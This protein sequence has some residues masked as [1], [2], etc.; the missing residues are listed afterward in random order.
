MPGLLEVLGLTKRPRDPQET[1]L[2]MTD[3]GAQRATIERARKS[4]AYALKNE[5]DEAAR[6]LT[7]LMA[8]L[9]SLA[10]AGLGV[11]EEA[12]AVIAQANDAIT[13][14]QAQV[15]KAVSN[16]CIAWVDAW[17][18][19]KQPLPQGDDALARERA[20]EL[21]HHV[22]SV[23]QGVGRDRALLARLQ[24]VAPDPDLDSLLPVLA[25]CEQQ[26]AAARTAWQQLLPKRS[27]DKP[28]AKAPKITR[29]EPKGVKDPVAWAKACDA[30]DLAAAQ[31]KPP[32]HEDLELMNEGAKAALKAEGQ[33]DWGA[34]L[35][36]KFGCSWDQVKAHYKKLKKD[37]DPGAQAFMSGYWWFRKTTVDAEMKKLAT[38]FGFEWESVGSTNPESDYDISVRTHGKREDRTVWDYEIVEMFNKAVSARFNGV[39]PGTLFDTN[40][41]ASAQPAEPESGAQKNATQKDMEAM[42][43]AG[44]D[45]G[46][47]MKM[48]RYMDWDDYVDYQDSALAEIRKTAAAE[49]NPE[50]RKLIEGRLQAAQRQFE[51]AD[52]L[53]FGKV[54]QTLAKAGIAVDPSTA[55]SPAGQ[56]VLIEQ[57]EALEKNP[58]KLMAANNAAYVEAMKG[59]R[60][61]E[62]ALQK[63]DA[64]LKALEG[65]DDP[66]AA[67]KRQQAG[68]RRAATM[69]KLETLQADSVFF[70]A[71]AYHSKGPFEHI[72]QAGQKSAQAVK[73]DPSIAEADQGKAIAKKV[74]QALDKLPL[75]AFMQSFNEQLGDLL[76]DLK[77]YE[78]ASP[79][80]GLGL[81]RSSKYLE[82]LCDAVDWIGKKLAADKT[83]A[84]AAKEFAAIKLFGKPAAQVKAELAGL[85][86]LRGG[87]IEFPEAADPQR[88]MEAWA[89]EEAQRV[90]GSG[91]KTLG[92]L[93]TAVKAV[94]K[95]VNIV[96]RKADVAS[97]AMASSE[98]AYFEGA[99]S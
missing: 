89:M 77:H 33:P 80:P 82:R 69:A 78:H 90:F 39:Q 76:K 5:P 37:K 57:L 65:Q 36:G 85:V 54:V 94:G 84:V 64:E 31:G 61:I 98:G 67:H 29:P 43:E 14:Q 86:D 11:G 56:K 4:L 50:R 13:E 66:A 73:A 92:D 38:A 91:V 18:H 74:A 12:S 44:Q 93:G 25:E 21:L 42:A 62:L 51:T 15:R 87:K 96:L 9:E 30:V 70:A 40:L 16:R 52:A 1:E 83:A 41:Y 2:E 53:Y 72:V 6:L 49:K 97:K 47:L 79:Y 24:R 19:L 10:S 8:E 35:K 32:K 48:R 7:R 60:E 23:E 17:E 71:E 27:S 34:D 59:V 26:A 3:V 88:E 45:V 55:D 99:R 22:S 68:D 81:Y 20:A 58:D 75:A 28:P 95:Q 46:A 63:I